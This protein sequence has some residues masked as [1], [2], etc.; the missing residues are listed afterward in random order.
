[1][2]KYWSATACF[3][4]GLHQVQPYMSVKKKGQWSFEFFIKK[5]E[6]V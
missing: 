2:R 5:C 1:M 4:A 6:V 3:L